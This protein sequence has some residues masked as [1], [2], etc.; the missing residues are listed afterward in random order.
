M[1][2][3]F[4]WFKSIV[5]LCLFLI[6]FALVGWYLDDML[7]AVALGAT[8]LLLLN[9][10]HLYK[11]NRWLWHSR[12]M[13]PPSVNG[14]WEHIYEGIYYLQRRNRNKRKEL[15]ALVKRF[16]EGSEAL[17]DAAVVVDAKACIIW[18]NRL[19]RLE[20]GL[21]WPSDAG[22][23]LDNLIRHP[24]FIQYFHAGKYHYPIEVPSP[25][26]PQKTF[27][28]RIMPYGE[29]HLLLIA[30]DVTRVSQ[31]E[32]M[33]KDFVANV[34]HELRTPLTVINGYLEILA[35]NGEELDPLTQKAFLEMSSQT[36]RMQSLIEDLLVLSRIE[37]SSERIYENTVDMPAMLRQIKLEADALNKD[38][39]HTIA[40]HLDEGVKIYGIETELRSACSNLIFNAINYTPPGGHIDVYWSVTKDGV[41]FAVKDDGDGIEQRHLSRLTE[42]FYRVDKARSRKTGGSGLGL[43]IVKHVLNH[44]NSQLQITSVVGEGSVFF[45]NFDAEMIAS[46]DPVL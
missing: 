4:S 25:L 32:E 35:G 19:A 46:Q 22:R 28:Y 10:W 18:C 9:Y 23:R 5:R 38:K 44:H 11:L 16:R 12:K 45:F 31:L 15:G 20:L 42:R 8:G 36:Q 13:S 30:R 29:E 34:S 40:F 14:L 1:Y 21:R 6:V 41:K 7:L 24:E 3:P 17:P 2:Y 37:A 33:R 39:G 26:N 27:E 43:S